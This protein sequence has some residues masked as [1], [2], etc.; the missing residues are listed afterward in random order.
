MIGRH[1]A[2]PSH[3]AFTQR[4]MTAHF[5]AL[6][7]L[8]NVI[9]RKKGLPSFVY[10]GSE[11]WRMQLNFYSDNNSAMSRAVWRIL[12]YPEI[13]WGEDQ[14]WAAEMLQL[15]FAKAYVDEAVVYHSHAFDAA[16]AFR[17][18][19][20]EGR[21][22]AET[23]WHQASRGCRGLAGRDEC[24][25]SRLRRRKTP[26][27]KRVEAAPQIQ[28]GGRERSAGRLER[29]QRSERDK[30]RRRI[31]VVTRRRVRW[32]AHDSGSLPSEKG[33]AEASSRACVSPTRGYE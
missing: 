30:A 11:P 1:E 7:L 21:F 14:V 16:T 26:L 10:P 28:R 15:G 32:I 3:D 31:A 20:T 12:P 25:R 6:A 18:A 23:F 8:P 9:S 22:W 33:E 2:Y 17:T 4:D 29:Q 27:I 24:A 19:E 5:D 13:D